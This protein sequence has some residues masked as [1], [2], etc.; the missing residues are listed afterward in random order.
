MR[1]SFLLVFSSCHYD[2][3]FQ[4]EVVKKKQ[5]WRK[6]FAFAFYL[7]SPSN[8][9]YPRHPIKHQE[10][11]ASVQR[12]LIRS[13]FSSPFSTVV[14]VAT[15]LDHRVTIRHKCRFAAAAKVFLSNAIP[16]EAD[17]DICVFIPTLTQSNCILQ[18]ELLALVKLFSASLARKSF[19]PSLKCCLVSSACHGYWPQ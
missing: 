12:V 11:F 16:T 5:I 8:S 9:N 15:L 6:C 10:K 4:H 1:G 14:V 2:G 7:Q 19:L 13:F 3:K 17:H 18:K